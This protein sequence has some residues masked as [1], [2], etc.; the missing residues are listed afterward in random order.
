[1][2]FTYHYDKTPYCSSCQ[3]P[4]AHEPS[5]G[6][7][8][9]TC[10]RVIPS[11]DFVNP[12]VHTVDLS[13]YQY[14]CPPPEPMLSGRTLCLYTTLR[15]G[16]CSPGHFETI[17]APEVARRPPP[18]GNHV[19]NIGDRLSLT[20]T[21][22]RVKDLPPGDWGPQFLAVLETPCGSRLIWRSGENLWCQE[23]QTHTFKGTVA[24]HSVYEGVKET[25]LKRCTEVKT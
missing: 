19:G 21:C 5:F 13:P 16:W 20:A 15:I 4:H 8:C 6:A 12:E 9:C 3:A 23:G 7:T 2:S 17:V 1:M 10:A 24:K 25:W 22:V 14:L 18:R 11:W